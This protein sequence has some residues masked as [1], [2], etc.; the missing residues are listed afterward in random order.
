MGTVRDDAES[1]DRMGTTL[2]AALGLGLGL[3]CGMV[4]SEMLG[5]VHPERVRSAVR[6]MREGGDSEVL[7]PEQVERNLLSALRGNP[8]TRGSDINVKALGDGLVELTGT[9]PDE[10]TRTI[11]RDLAVAAA[12]AE[13]VVNRLLVE[14]VD[15]GE[16]SVKVRKDS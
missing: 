16:S 6:R 4:L 9:V 3:V 8:T 7:D 10:R 11:A 12:G 13:V 2:F 5:N 1:H 15:T 14:G